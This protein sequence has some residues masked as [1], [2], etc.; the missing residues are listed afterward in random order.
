MCVEG[1]RVLVKFESISGP[2]QHTSLGESPILL[3]SLVDHCYDQATII[4]WQ[5]EKPRKI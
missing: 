5:A 2:T 3:V 1:G 4:D